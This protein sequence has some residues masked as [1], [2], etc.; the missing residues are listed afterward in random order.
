MGTD[1]W[2]RV[3]CGE[4]MQSVGGTGRRYGS[5]SFGGL[6]GLDGGEQ[7]ERVI[8]CVDNSGGPDGISFAHAAIPSGPLPAQRDVVFG[9]T[10]SMVW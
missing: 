1:G 2:R 4:D 8:L 5:R 9:D 10:S 3:G 7:R 6:N